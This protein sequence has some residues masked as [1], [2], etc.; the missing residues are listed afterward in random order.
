MNLFQSLSYF[1]VTVVT[2]YS[3]E[4]LQHDDLNIM[5]KNNGPGKRRAIT[6]VKQKITRF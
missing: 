1:E 4:M 5:L 6:V 3:L 2:K